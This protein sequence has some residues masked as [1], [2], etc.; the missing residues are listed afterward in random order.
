M[1]DADR[2]AA[3]VAVGLEPMSGGMFDAIVMQVLL[4]VPAA[5]VAGALAERLRLPAVL[6]A[7][8]VGLLVGP[9]V[10]GQASPGMYERLFVG[11]A[12]T[13]ERI[14]QL[15]AEREAERRLLID[16]DVTDTE[17]ERHA[18]ETERLLDPLRQ[19]QAAERAAV[20]TAFELWS[21][22]VI[23]LALLAAGMATPIGRLRSWLIDATGPAIGGLAVVALVG[24]GAAWLLGMAAADGGR[25]WLIAL[26]LGAAAASWPVP[27][28]VR[29]G[30]DPTP[31]GGA[32][33]AKG[34]I[35]NRPGPA[36][37]EDE[38]PL[39]AA[40]PL[41]MTLVVWVLLGGGLVGLGDGAGGA[42][43]VGWTVA[44]TAGLAIAAVGAVGPLAAVAA[45]RL[46]M[47][48][49]EADALRVLVGLA[50]AAAAW[51]ATGTHPAAAAV[52]AGLTI[53]CIGRGKEQDEA[54]AD[55]STAG[56][57]NEP[58][59]SPWGAAAGRLWAWAG[60]AATAAIASRIDFA[61]LDATGWSV[62]GW[63]G[64]LVAVLLTAG[65]GKAM[66]VLLGV[67]LG[68][69]RG[70]RAA[71]R[72]GSATAAGGPMTAI[73][74]YL[75]W[76]AGAADMALLAALVAA[77]PIMAIFARMALGLAREVGRL[78]ELG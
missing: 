78:E 25:T 28:W 5:V 66:G 17:V 70:W 71:L 18:A 19:R 13:G 43:A 22:A 56:C 1:P 40:T 50:V 54:A 31:V 64:L 68:A 10:L 46:R 32:G 41:L 26:L 34:A 42:A 38:R 36:G 61:E 3:S 55:R 27:A 48:T 65:D 39:Q 7:V 37:L 60:L 59:A 6:G 9:G 67:R 53:A 58:G 75:L 72:I 24:A 49:R 20:R 15:R 51:G 29:A 8:V 30:L 63:L 45:R 12:A 69:N 23:G 77:A 11:G 16:I 4:I 35:G 57:A 74:A 14:E 73:V 33:P 21:G 44:A 52:I 2:A 76:R 47:R 62:A